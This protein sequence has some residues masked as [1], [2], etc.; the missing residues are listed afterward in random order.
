VDLNCHS[1]RRTE[2]E[3]FDN[4]IHRKAWSENL[5][6]TWVAGEWRKWVSECLHWIKLAENSLAR[7]CECG[8]KTVGLV[9][10]PADHQRF[11]KYPACCQV[12]RPESRKAGTGHV[13]CF[14]IS[15]KAAAWILL[16]RMGRASFFCQGPSVRRG[17]EQGNLESECYVHC[18]R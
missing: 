15:W 13:L 16:Y 2:V 9:S 17:K 12:N 18:R 6:T 11:K 3:E 10:L 1:K 7:S 8:S 5:Q 14:E 4:R